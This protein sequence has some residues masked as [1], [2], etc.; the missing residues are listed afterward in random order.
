MSVDRQA[1]LA[2]KPLKDGLEGQGGSLQWCGVGWGM[3]A[4]SSVMP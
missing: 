1:K 2:G 3:E 4:L